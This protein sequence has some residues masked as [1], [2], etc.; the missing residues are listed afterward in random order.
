MRPT[1]NAR[2]ILRQQEQQHQGREQEQTRAAL[3]REFPDVAFHSFES[4]AREQDWN[5]LL[6]GA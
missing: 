3:R 2:E 6:R 4:W 5:T 1:P